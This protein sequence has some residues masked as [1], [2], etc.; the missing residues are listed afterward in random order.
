MT[1][2]QK[3]FRRG[4]VLEQSLPVYEERLEQE[5]MAL[6]VHNAITNKHHLLVEAG[7]GVG[8]TFGYSVPLA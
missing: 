2:V 8:K 3:I 1:R 6:C 7:C 5:Q 4:G